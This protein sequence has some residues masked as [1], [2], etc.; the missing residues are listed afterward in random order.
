[1]KELFDLQAREGQ[2]ESGSTSVKKE[3]SEIRGVEK[4]PS[5]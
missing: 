5:T 4:T 3:K 1:L 2:G